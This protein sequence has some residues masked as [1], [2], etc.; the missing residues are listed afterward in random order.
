M[1]DFI[2]KIYVC[3]I[4]SVNIEKVKNKLVTDFK[5]NENNIKFNIMPKYNC[6]IKDKS[7]TK[8]LFYKLSKEEIVNKSLSCTENHLSVFKD[9]VENK[10]PFILVF[11][12]DVELLTTEK[13]LKVALKLVE[14]FIRYNKDW[15]LFYL[16]HLPFYLD[17][18]ETKAY[19]SFKILKSVSWCTHAYFISEKYMKK[20]INFTPEQMLN[21][22]AE[23]INNKFFFSQVI[24]SGGIDTF[25]V[26]DK[27]NCYSIYPQIITQ[28]S[29]PNYETYSRCLENFSYNFPSILLALFLLFVFNTE[30]KKMKVTLLS[31]IVILLLVRNEIRR[32]LVG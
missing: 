20:L 9:A 6:K 3:T 21:M 16:G 13:E 17:N 25:Y 22:S 27:N 24:N 7:V 26:T 30:N 1:W 28:T 12:D 31:I 32:H 2:P 14:K 19:K 8:K 15:D 23:K 4:D 10:H 5:I 29:I 18:V 11:E